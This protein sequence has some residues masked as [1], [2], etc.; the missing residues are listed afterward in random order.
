MNR[1][2]LLLLIDF[3]AFSTPAFAQ[4][5]RAARWGASPEE[6]YQAE[7][8]QL[9][10]SRDSVLTYRIPLSDSTLTAG[11]SYHF[12][13]DGLFRVVEMLEA[14]GD[15][16]SRHIIQFLVAEQEMISRYGSPLTPT[17]WDQ[18]EAFGTGPEAI[19]AINAGSLQLNSRWEVPGTLILLR[20]MRAENGPAV[21]TIYERR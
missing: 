11:V 17:T 15:D 12:D 5:Y 19:E 6:I 4:D 14:P 18:V 16:E 3:L 8:A 9:A 7:T 1:L 21:F 13:E 2:R 10:L 20:L